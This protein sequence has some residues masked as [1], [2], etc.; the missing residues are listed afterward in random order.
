[1]RK[2]VLITIAFSYNS[3]SA[4]SFS[5]S[6]NVS[7]PDFGEIGMLYVTSSALKL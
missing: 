4:L 7:N 1:M 5:Y 6:E 2:L 3:F